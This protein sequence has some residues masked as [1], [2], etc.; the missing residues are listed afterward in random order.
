MALTLKEREGF[1]PHRGSFL[2][3]IN[4][5]KHVSLTLQPRIRVQCPQALS[6]RLQQCGLTITAFVSRTPAEREQWILW[7]VTRGLQ[8]LMGGHTPVCD[9]IVPHGRTTCVSLQLSASMAHTRLDFEYLHPP[10]GPSGEGSLRQTKIP[11]RGNRQALKGGHI[12][13]SPSVPVFADVSR[14]PYL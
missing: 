12:G 13:S 2:P 3:V 10:L 1:G 6:L 7:P 14:V 9:I 8:S 4:T 5:I 11:S